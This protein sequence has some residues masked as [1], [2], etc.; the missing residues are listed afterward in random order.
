MTTRKRKPKTLDQRAVDRTNKAFDE[1]GFLN[2]WTA[3]HRGFCAG[4]IA[5]RK[6]K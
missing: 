2:T 5:A 3:Y 1:N 6:H 4:W